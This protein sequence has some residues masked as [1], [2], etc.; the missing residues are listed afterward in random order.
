MQALLE[1]NVSMTYP[2]RV[3]QAIY[4][5]RYMNELVLI[6]TN[7]SKIQS[8]KTSNSKKTLVQLTSVFSSK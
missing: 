7:Q 6:L 5:D 1:S 3:L 2:F 4:V 8:I